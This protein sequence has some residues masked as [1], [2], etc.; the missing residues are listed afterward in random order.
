VRQLAQSLERVVLV[1]GGPRIAA[2]ELEALA[3][4]ER[5]EES[6]PELPRPGSMTLDQMERAMIGNCLR[7]F[8]GNLSRA[9][10]ALGLSRAAL[11]RRLGKHGLARD[12]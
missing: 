7:H 4:L 3:R 12:G 6:E 10:E 2:A 9:A 11:Y 1:G 5:P 8:D